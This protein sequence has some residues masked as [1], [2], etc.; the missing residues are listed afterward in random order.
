MQE[1]H[2]R[3]QQLL[4]DRLRRERE[5]REL[6]DRLRRQREM[7]ERMR[8]LHTSPTHYAAAPTIPRAEVSS[9]GVRHVWA[10]AAEPEPE[11]ER[12]RGVSVTCPEGAGACSCIL[13]ET[14]RS[15]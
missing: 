2:R 1:N 15:L 14:D 9:D 12:P 11:P 6:F 5:Q 10:T 4:Q 13:Y 8:R 7:D 3:Q